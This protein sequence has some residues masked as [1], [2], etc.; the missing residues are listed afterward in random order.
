MTP[1]M[2]LFLRFLLA[3]ALVLVMLSLSD[4]ALAATPVDTVHDALHA[5]GPQAAHFVDL[6]RVFLGACT[7]VFAAI[8]V[9]LFVALRRAPRA[10]EATPADLSTVNRAEPLPRRH[11]TRAVV[12]SG[13]TLLALIV[14]SVFTDR[15]MARLSLAHAVNVEVTGHQWWW[16]VRYLD[17]PNTS[18]VFTTANE[19]HIP[20]GVPVVIKLR[21]DDVIH[22]LWVPSLAG[23][24]DLIP[25]RTATLQLRADTPGIYRGQCAEFCGLEH[26]LMGLLIV[27]EPQAQYEQWVAAQKQPAPEPQDAQ[28]QRGKQVFQSSSCAMC[29]AI[30]GA[31]FAGAQHGPDL[32]HVASR[33]TLAS[34][35]LKNTREEMAAWIRDPQVHKPGTAMPATPLSQEDLDAVVAYLGG[36]K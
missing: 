5:F 24:K 28:A 4:Y 26:A 25:G 21:A 10:D 33:Q 30:V 34:G 14:A 6:W 9:A 32:T 31:D 16:G 11:V 7:F 2:S 20:V 19:M 23:K 3:V 27:A 18:D 1:M 13:L 12:A 35:T 15:A 8:L 36:L 22:S 17:G 29:H